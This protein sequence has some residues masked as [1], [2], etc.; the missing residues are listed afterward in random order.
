MRT[1]KWD[2]AN[3]GGF[4]ITRVLQGG[5]VFE[6]AGCNISVV[7]GILPPAAAKQMASRGHDLGEGSVPFYACGISLV[8]HPHNPN[9]PTVHAN[10][11]YFEVSDEITRLTLWHGI[12]N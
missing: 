3:N 5:N 6:K 2:R 9:A 1:D 11:R 10:Y 4:G 8:F 12:T 7:H